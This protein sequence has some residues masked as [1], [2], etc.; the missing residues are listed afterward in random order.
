MEYWFKW[1][2]D[3]SFVCR[4]IYIYVVILICWKRFLLVIGMYEL[5]IDLIEMESLVLK[6]SIYV[7]KLIYVFYIDRNVL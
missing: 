3:I 2:L 1:D 4:V 6:K 7:W 5:E